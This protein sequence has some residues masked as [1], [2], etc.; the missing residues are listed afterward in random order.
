MI[1]FGNN[2]S[3]QKRVSAPEHHKQRNKW[4]LPFGLKIKI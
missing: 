4:G 2:Q 1:N 3:T